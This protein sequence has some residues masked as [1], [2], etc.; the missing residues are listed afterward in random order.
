M[1]AGSTVHARVVAHVG[2]N[3]WQLAIGNRTVTA[4]V[5]VPV[6]LGERFLARVE[7]SGSEIILRQ[8]QRGSTGS[9]AL[10]RVLSAAGVP[11]NAVSEAILTHLV[12]AQHSLDPT[13][14]AK[15]YRMAERAGA[16][17]RR[18]AR[19]LAV[20]VGK[21]VDVDDEHTFR[22][23]L[24][25]LDPASEGDQKGRDAGDRRQQNPRRRENG[26]DKDTSDQSL[27]F[28]APDSHS[29]EDLKKQVKSAVTRTEAAAT[30]ALPVVNHRIGDEGHWVV[31]PVVLSVGEET[32]RAVV[33]LYR[34]GPADRFSQGALEVELAG[35]RI[36]FSILRRDAGFRVV[37]H[38]S[39]QDDPAAR[40]LADTLTQTDLIRELV[41]R[42]SLEDF[43]GFSSEDLSGIVSG[44]DTDV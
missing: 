40:N 44:V 20:L 16:R 34:P 22:R 18:E 37:V 39:A 28:Q 1:S 41:F 10:A 12:H 8:I 14:I 30:S 21:G 24:S 23:L 6:H 32:R 38:P 17:T 15:L 36:A 25:A 2:K 27:P 42:D 29:I 33:R 3:T 35:R 5:A 9:S 26:D 13:R 31:V 11:Q 19:L 4:R 43:D 7:R